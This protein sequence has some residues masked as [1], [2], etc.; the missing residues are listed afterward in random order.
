MAETITRVQD[1]QGTYTGQGLT[2]E[3]GREEM[4]RSHSIISDNP[5]QFIVVAS[6]E[7]GIKEIER[8]GDQNSSP[9]YL[10]GRNL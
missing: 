7:W 4:F 3:Y 8:S 6:K 1:D 9:F 10:S 2:E 5:T